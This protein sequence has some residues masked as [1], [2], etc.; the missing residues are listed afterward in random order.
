MIV[1]FSFHH[2]SLIS[3]VSEPSLVHLFS[4]LLCSWLVI[5]INL[6]QLDLSWL[7]CVI[8]FLFIFSD[9]GVQESMIW[10]LDFLYAF[11]W[12]FNSMAQVTDSGNVTP[13]VDLYVKAKHG[14][15]SFVALEQSLGTHPMMVPFAIK[16]DSA[17]YFIWKFQLESLIIAYG[18]DQFISSNIVVPSQF[19]EGLS[20]V[21]LG[22][23]LIIFSRA[24]CIVQFQILWWL[25]LWEK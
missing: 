6:L 25:I 1:F 3:M 4:F 20:D 11:S 19:L 7:S 23:E 9:R 14:D 5:L 2:F 18:L 10:F 21:N 12:I 15:N 16:L 8:P 17:N 22:I 13:V 24:G